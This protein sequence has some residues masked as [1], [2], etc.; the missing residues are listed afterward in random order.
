M[1][2]K[3][4]VDLSI[5]KHINCGLGQ[6]ALNYGKYF[7]EH[8]SSNEI[9]DLYL[10]VP[11]KM[12]GKF[13][14]DVNYI[15]SG[16]WRKFLPFFSLRVDVWHSIHQLSSFKPFHRCT[17]TIL[18][19]HD[20]N[21]LYEKSGFKSK[22]YLRKVQQ[23]IDEAARVVC[24]SNFSKSETE[25]FIDLKGKSIEVIYNGVEQFDIERTKIPV[26]FKNS[27][28]FFFTIGQIKKKKN[29]HVLLPLMKLFP[30][31][32]LYIA[33]QTGTAYAD[34]IQAVIRSE[35]I[36]NVHLV[37]TVSN[38]ERVWLYKNCEAFL[39]PSL[40]EGFGLPVIEAMYFG[41]PVF[42]TGETSLKEIGGGHTTIWDNFDPI[43]MKN[44]VDEALREFRLSPSRGEQN[45]EYAK[46]F[47]YEKHM[48]SYV[49]LYKQLLM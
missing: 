34:Q 24:I 17:K 45:I 18:T 2:K 26:F 9:Y 33:G 40:F 11:R 7:K 30:E 36:F 22:C 8:Y 32:E 5:L 10:L 1:K 6:V 16:N 48:E 47:S 31:N 21:I 15:S 44:I 4:L 23:E 3:V 35:N 42:T 39:F 43:Y 49:E 12:F 25:R 19:I 37:G 20:F 38:E 41:K 46:S 29:F 28:P 13:G 27:K 14:S